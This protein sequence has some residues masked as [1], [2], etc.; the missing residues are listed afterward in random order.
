MSSI[1]DRDPMLSDLL[2]YMSDCAK[3]VIKA[4]EEL[5]RRQE[6]Y[7]LAVRQVA[8]AKV[9]RA[10]ALRQERMRRMRETRRR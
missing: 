7:Q 3:D 8:L 6:R 9:D 5:E 10:V 4:Q 2:R 1:A